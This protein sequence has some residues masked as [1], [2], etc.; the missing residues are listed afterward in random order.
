[1]YD[2]ARGG[3]ERSTRTMQLSVGEI[4]G[5]PDAQHLA[6]GIGQH[7]VFPQHP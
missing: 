6:S 1:L 2:D 4:R 7:T 3:I 5:R